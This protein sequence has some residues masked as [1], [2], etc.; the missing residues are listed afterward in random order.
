MIGPLRANKHDSS[1]NSLLITLPVSCVILQK[2]GTIRQLMTIYFPI[3]M[4]KDAGK[5]LN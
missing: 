1:A 2:L 4:T 3:L 5:S